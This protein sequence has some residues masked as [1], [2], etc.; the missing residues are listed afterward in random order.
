MEQKLQVITEEAD[1]DG[2]ET[3]GNYRRSLPRWNRNYR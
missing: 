2:A 1:Q 3:T